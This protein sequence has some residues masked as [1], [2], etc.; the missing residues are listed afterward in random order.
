MSLTPRPGAVLVLHNPQCS[1]SR[2]LVAELERRGV[3]FDPR[4]Y[5]D[6]PLSRV[7]LEELLR[8]TGLE[9]HA[10]L[11]TKETEYGEAGL[12]TG[13]SRRAILDALVAH[14]RLLERPILISAS[15]AAIGRPT[16][17]ALAVLD[18]AQ[19]R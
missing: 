8:L 12:S 11:R 4:R 17:N 2:Q 15:R 18:D 19:A 5:L 9:P 3:D 7:E 16:E 6:R 14:P 10:L 1:K 13:S